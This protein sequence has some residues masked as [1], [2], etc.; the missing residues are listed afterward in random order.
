MMLIMENVLAIWLLVSRN[1]PSERWLEALKEGVPRP[2]PPDWLLF[3]PG[4]LKEEMT[5]TKR[6]G[7]R[8]HNH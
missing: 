1:I 4:T 8:L 6:N 3:D 2:D 5:T 7:R